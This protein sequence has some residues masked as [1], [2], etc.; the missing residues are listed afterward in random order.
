MVCV[1]QSS[2]RPYSLKIKKMADLYNPNP[3][4][5]PHR[6]NISQLSHRNINRIVIAIHFVSALVILYSEVPV[7]SHPIK[8]NRAQGSGCKR[9]CCIM[10]INRYGIRELCGGKSYSRLTAATISCV[11][12][13]R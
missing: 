8:M 5:K 11:R 9:R 12:F 13:P 6:Y 3:N 7:D 1:N 10:L 4:V 2:V